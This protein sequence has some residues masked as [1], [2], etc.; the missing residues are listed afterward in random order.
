MNK[1]GLGVSSSSFEKLF[2]YLKST[3]SNLS[4]YEYKKPLIRDKNFLISVCLDCNLKK[5]YGHIEIGGLEIV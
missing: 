2:E 3:F 4:Y 1:C 5:K